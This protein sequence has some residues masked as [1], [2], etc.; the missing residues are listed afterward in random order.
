MS[1]RPESEILMKK[2]PG[3]KV[4]NVEQNLEQGELLSIYSFLSAHSSIGVVSEP[5][6]SPKPGLFPIYICLQF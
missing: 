2:W 5:K 6:Q 1:R 4:F 3:F